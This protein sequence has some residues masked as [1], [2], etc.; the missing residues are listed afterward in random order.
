MR[1]LAALLALLLP[2][3]ALAEPSAEPSL[4]EPPATERPLAAPPL[5]RPC[6]PAPTQSVSLPVTRDALAHAAPVTIVAFGSS[7]TE[8]A[9]SSGPEATYPARLEAQ[10]RA[11]LPGV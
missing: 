11:T 9:G 8:G 7:S 2:A 10:L 1:R 3:A 5:A 4:A 6:P